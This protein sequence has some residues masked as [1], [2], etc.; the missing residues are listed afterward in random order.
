M[1]PA[2]IPEPN[3]GVHIRLSD[4]NYVALV[5]RA[6]QDRLTRSDVVN[7]A[8]AAYLAP[9]AEPVRAVS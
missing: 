2:P 7:R 9:V 8:L 3:R 6:A 5:T 1:K 4:A